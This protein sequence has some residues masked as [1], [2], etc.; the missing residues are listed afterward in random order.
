M[1]EKQIDRGIWLLLFI[2]PF[3]ATLARSLSKFQQFKCEKLNLKDFVIQLFVGTTSGFLFGLLGCWIIGNY[4]GA[5]G[6]ISGFG[7]VLGITGVGRIAEV[8]ENW[9]IDKFK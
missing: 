4:E 9:L 1:P 3:F 7:A 2:I 6:A 5:V 8:M